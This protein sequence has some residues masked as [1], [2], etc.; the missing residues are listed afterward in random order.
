MTATPGSFPPPL[1]EEPIALSYSTAAG[2]PGK[3]RRHEPYL[4]AA[5]L[6][7]LLSGMAV[8]ILILAVAPPAVQ[9]EKGVVIV[10]VGPTQ[11]TVN[12]FRGSLLL[13]GLLSAGCAIYWLIWI[14]I[15]H[16]EMHV[17]TEGQY[18]VSPARAVGFC[19]IPFFNLLWIVWMPHRLAQDLEFRLGPTRARAGRVLTFQALS[20]F[21]GFMLPGLGA[22]FRGIAMSTLQSALNELWRRHRPAAATPEPQP[23]ELAARFAAIDEG[24][25]EI[26]ES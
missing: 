17:F 2:L 20:L 26:E 22:L 19:F 7:V 8:L 24:E 1:P 9:T 11:A 14:A 23:D 6:A 15:V 4:M 10:G 18:P 16:R 13:C 25:P 12:V 21:A 5:V 3:S